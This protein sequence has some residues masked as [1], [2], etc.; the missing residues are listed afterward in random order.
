MR[1]ATM[2]LV[3]PGVDPITGE[4]GGPQLDDALV[5][6]HTPISRDRMCA[7]YTS[8]ADSVKISAVTLW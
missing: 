2:G 8:G 7:G 1:I 4:L 5:L 6:F 3:S